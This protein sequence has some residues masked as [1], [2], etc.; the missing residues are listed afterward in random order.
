VSAFAW[1]H[2]C[3]ASF[4]LSGEARWPGPTVITLRSDIDHIVVTAPS[5]AIGV[6]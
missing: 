4:T 3:Q 1:R 2:I 6:Q 5:P